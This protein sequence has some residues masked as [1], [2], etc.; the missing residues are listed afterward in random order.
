MAK[1]KLM[2]F[3]NLAEKKKKKKTGLPPIFLILSDN[4]KPTIFQNNP[5]PFQLI[6]L[7]KL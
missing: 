2:L 7:L 1:I 3:F 5:S 4:P 6:R